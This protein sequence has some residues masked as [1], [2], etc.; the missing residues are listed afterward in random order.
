MS[1]TREPRCAFDYLIDVERVLTDVRYHIQDTY[2]ERRAHL[3]NI[4]S[5]VLRYER[6]VVERVR[7]YD[8]NEYTIAE[9]RGRI[10]N[11]K[12]PE[13]DRIV[14]N[15]SLLP[16]ALWK[17][18]YLQNAITKHRSLIAFNRQEIESISKTVNNLRE[19]LHR[20]DCLIQYN[21][22]LRRDAEQQKRK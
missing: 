17:K 22:E 10:V 4:E 16:M 21:D 6:V 18:N 1:P 3:L 7:E 14:M 5:E 11:P 9:Y 15:D 2:E 20:V 8:R 19:E 13:H 12:T